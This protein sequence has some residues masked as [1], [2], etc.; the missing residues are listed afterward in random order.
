MSFSA[1]RRKLAASNIFNC[2]NLADFISTIVAVLPYKG[3][4]M[5][6][7]YICEYE[8]VRFLTKFCFYQKSSPEIYGKAT[9]G[10]VSHIDA[11]INIL[12]TFKEKV[13][14]KN[15]TP[16]ILELVYETTC[17]GISKL[18]PKEKICERLMIDYCETLPED[19]VEQLV[20]KYNELVKNG[21]A[22]DKCAF[23]VLEKCDMSL[24]IYLRKN[25]NTSVSLAVFKS[26]LF[27]IIY[28][29]YALNRIYP[30]FRHF[31]LHTENIM[32]KFDPNYKFKATNP[33]FLLFTIDGETYSVPYFGIIPKIIDFGFSSL[34]EEGIISVA[35]ENRMQM[36]YRAD[37]DLLYLFH[38]IHYTLS[39]AKGDKL[40]RVDKLLTHLEPNHA[41]V[42]YSTPYIR[43]IEDKIPTY[44]QMIKNNV[45][46]EYKKY[47]VP[48]T[49]VYNEFTPIEELNK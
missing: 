16:C 47:K 38:W 46:D 28:T 23:L 37:N 3:V 5:S 13:I 10:M 39:R 42:Q 21:L 7:F 40:S 15:I 49:Q 45:W 27:M 6:R 44:E 9:K 32:L 14:N 18:T 17:E 8:G 20:C 11:E 1:V 30:R 19:D 33:K 34:P 2:S 29:I 26:L 4:S 24:D 31:D 22:H 36:Y 35:T 25:I 12:I 41:Y 48:K 43:K